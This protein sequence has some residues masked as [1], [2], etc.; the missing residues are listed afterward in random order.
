[1]RVPVIINRKYYM[2][3]INWFFTWLGL[4]LLKKSMAVRLKHE[5]AFWMQTIPRGMVFNRNDFTVRLC[6]HKNVL[7]LG[8]ADYPFTEGK[9]KNNQLLH[10]HLKAVTDKLY[11]IDIEERAVTM[12]KQL[13]GDESVSAMDINDIPDNIFKQF[14]VI[15]AG[16]ILE[17]LSN[18]LSL[19][20][21]LESKMKK[22]QTLLITVP[23]YLALDN[24]AAT[25]HSKESVHPDHYW[26]FSP[27]TI[28]KLF[29]NSIW[30]MVSLD[31]GMYYMPGKQ[32]NAL[33]KQFTHLGDCIIIVFKIK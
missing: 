32:P 19:I 7:H 12:Y 33:L 28:L 18:P 27:Y 26:Y 29:D 17:H 14:E 3:K 10:L 25:L 6:T 20:S 8:F 22:G 9:I 1:M 11:G 2:K 4:S 23:N 30:E 16:E 13:T 15:V 31:F 5:N 21:K 24:I